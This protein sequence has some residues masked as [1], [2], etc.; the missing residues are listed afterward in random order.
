MIRILSDSTCDLSPELVAR[1][2]I[3]IMPLTVVLG[4]EEFTDGVDITPNE[5]FAWSDRTR[6]TPKTAVFS[7]QQV[8]D[9]F[10]EYLNNG[11]ELICFS[12]SE[13]MSSSGQVMRM[14]AKDLHAEDRIHVIDSQN[15]STGIGLL[16]LRA[17]DLLAE[18]KTA[19]E[20]VQAVEALRNKVRS[21]FVIDTMTYL[22]R[23]GRCSGLVALM[24]NALRIHPKI[25]VD[26]GKM[27]PDSKYRGS[28]KR[29][30]SRY[31]EDLIPAMQHADKARVF[32]THSTCEPELVEGVIA[33]V[34]A[35]H[36]FDEILETTAGSVVSS[37][38]GPATLGILFVDAD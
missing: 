8:K 34:K 27:R 2:R 20:T 5:I 21:S 13:T 29:V 17:A 30:L 11:D 38:C 25:V 32:V 31:T 19:A 3:D 9:R 37:H 10:R 24:G 18:G 36:H 22:H 4:E 16:I 12:I 35:L 14:A 1:Y 6:Q 26:G 15:L 7:V 33:D 23:G 28:M